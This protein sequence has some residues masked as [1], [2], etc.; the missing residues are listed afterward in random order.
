MQIEYRERTDL[1]IVQKNGVILAV[2][3][4]AKTA[5]E[6]LILIEAAERYEPEKTHSMLEEL[7]ERMQ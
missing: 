5:A 2:C 4:C 7:A 3:S 6:E 1:W